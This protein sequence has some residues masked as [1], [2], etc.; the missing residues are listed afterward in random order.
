MKLLK[1]S[2]LIIFLI[3]ITE[4]KA[5]TLQKEQQSILA[6]LTGKTKI[7]QYKALN[8]RYSIENRAIARN[9]LGDWI[10][11]LG[12]NLKEHTYRID[13]LRRGVTKN[14]EGKNI[15]T[16]IPSTTK[17][18]EYII[19]GAHFDSVKNCPGAN[20]NA[21]GCALVYGV[22]KQLKALKIRTKNTIV[23]YFDQEELG[24]VGSQAFTNF[25]KEKKLNVH[26]VHTIDQMGWDKDKDQNIEIEVPTPFL[27]SIYQKHAEKLGVSAFVTPETGSD[28]RTFRAAGYNA[29]GITEEYRNKDT[30]PHY[31]QVTDTYDTVN[32]T[33]L[34][35]ST[36]LVF[37]V[38]EELLTK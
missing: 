23:V 15:Y 26:S 37:N 17:S 34:S 32:F 36:N 21:T 24:C 1:I 19:I 9:F 8:D 5:Q 31:H 6:G 20:D 10:K 3:T 35:F 22:A 16:M 25:I 28:H 18:D 2:F 27:K 38:I 13:M 33:Y 4:S 30:T 12:L 14:Y 11:E 29:V 7:K